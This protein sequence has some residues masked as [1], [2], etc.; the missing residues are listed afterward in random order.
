MNFFSFLTRRLQVLIFTYFF[1]LNHSRRYYCVLYHSSSLH[2]H[3]ST[4]ALFQSLFDLEI[5]IKIRQV[6]KRFTY[7]TI[8]LARFFG[9]KFF[10]ISNPLFIFTCRLIFLF[11]III[12]SDF[13]GLN[14]VT[15]HTT[16]KL[17]QYLE[18]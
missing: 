18:P 13:Y 14:K 8:I 6:H 4:Y 17:K 12:F 1:L 3:T 16:E 11:V 2:L 5:G 7:N 15:F 9:L 10:F